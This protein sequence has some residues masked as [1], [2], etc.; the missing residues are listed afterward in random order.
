[1]PINTSSLSE[2]FDNNQTELTAGSSPAKHY[3]GRTPL[4]VMRQNGV[5]TRVPE[6]L[7]STALNIA[8]PSVPKAF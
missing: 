2:Q 6:E 4:G 1:M 8:D 5:C 3:F 7:R